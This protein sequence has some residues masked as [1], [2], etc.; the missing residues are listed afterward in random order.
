MGGIAGPV[1]NIAD[2]WVRVLR[3]RSLG[4][5]VG[6]VGAK[7]LLLRRRD[8][9]GVEALLDEGAG[10]RRTGDLAGLAGR[11]FGGEGRGRGEERV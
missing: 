10:W 8:L 11:C 5:L 6:R 3:R 9:E 1:L 4:L 7:P 2:H